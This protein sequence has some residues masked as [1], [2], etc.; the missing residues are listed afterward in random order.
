MTRTLAG[1]LGVVVMC[2]A[3]LE[4]QQAERSGRWGV[5]CSITPRWTAARPIAEYVGADE[6]DISGGELSIGLVRGRD[7]SGDW[8]ASVVW[9]GVSEGSTSRF[10]TRE[11]CGRQDCIEESTTIVAKNVS[12]LGLEAHTFFRLVNLGRRVHLGVGA[13]GG[14]L[15]VR[16]RAEKNE[17]Y[18]G[19]ALDPA[20]GTVILTRRSNVSAVGGGQVFTTAKDVENVLSAKLEI[21]VGL[22][23]TRSLKA[24]V[25]SGIDF[26]GYHVASLKLV[27][28][29][30]R[31]GPESIF[32]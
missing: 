12:M 18:A 29:F 7:Y 27:Y 5:V 13:A 25:S 14:I 9:K 17:R 31:P 28:L 20:T 19:F 10:D 6:Y 32:R 2:P 11:L 26:P 30:G 1:I 24:R 21:G 3:L 15:R 8:G 16:G 23:L 22:I 4:A